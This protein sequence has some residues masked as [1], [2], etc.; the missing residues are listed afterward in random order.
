MRKTDA[1]VTVVVCFDWNFVQEGNPQLREP[2]CLGLKASRWQGALQH[3][4][5]GLRVPPCCP[6][7][8]NKPHCHC[9]PCKLCSARDKVVYWTQMESL[10]PTHKCFATALA[11][12]KLPVLYQSGTEGA[13][14]LISV[15]LV[16]PN[17]KER[18]GN[19]IV[20][21]PKRSWKVHNQLGR[22]S[23]GL[24]PFCWQVYNVEKWNC[25]MSTNRK[26][27]KTTVSQALRQK[28]KQPQLL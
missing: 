19:I 23:A 1:Q 13:H 27:S 14:L 10:E 11:K 8:Q 26:N 16:W 3:S 25:K 9:C 22:V 15:F 2:S 17:L 12:N 24:P 21:L 18:E 7:L 20:L 6:S 4:G 5:R 28:L